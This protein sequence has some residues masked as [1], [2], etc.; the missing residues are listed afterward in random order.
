ML[1]INKMGMWAELEALSYLQKMGFILVAQNFHSRFGEIDLIM[2][3]DQ[4]LIFVEVKAR[5]KTKYGL[6]HEVISVTKQ[7]KIM[8]TAL[9]FLEKQQSYSHFYCRFD[10][11]CFNFE[12]KFSKSIHYDFENCQYDLNWIENA[13]TF[14]SEFINL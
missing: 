4:D 1:K 9:E 12:Q 10:V 5:S 7:R 11:I 14:D 13:F 3:K 8:H 6:A 2:K